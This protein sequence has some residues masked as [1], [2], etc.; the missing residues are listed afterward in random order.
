MMN[1]D[2]YIKMLAVKEQYDNAKREFDEEVVRGWEQQ[3]GYERGKSMIGNALYTRYVPIN[4]YGMGVYSIM[5]KKI[6]RKGQLA[7]FDCSIGMLIFNG[8]KYSYEC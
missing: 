5:G 6:N 8:E 2:K 4:E 7:E 1:K 3:N